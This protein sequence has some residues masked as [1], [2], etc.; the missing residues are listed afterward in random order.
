MSS[1]ED[2]PREFLSPEAF[3]NHD[4]PIAEYR[5]N[6]LIG[7]LGSI[8]TDKQIQDLLTSPFT[9]T[10]DAKQLPRHLKP[11]AAFALREFFLPDIPHMATVREIDLLIRQSYKRRNPLNRAYLAQILEDTKTL[12]HGIMLP[13]RYLFVPSLG[14]T[15]IGPPGN[16]K[17]LSCDYGLRDWAPA[18]MHSYIIK[19]ER[20]SF[21]QIPAMKINLFQDGSLKSFGL[22]IFN[23]G[24]QI[25]GIPLRRDWGVDAA[26]AGNWI[27]SLYMQFCL[28]YNVGLFVI[29]EFQ[30]I[31][32][33]HEG[34][35]RALSYFVRLMN[36]LGVAMIVVGT[37]HTAK[38]LSGDMAASRRF[39]GSIPQFAPFVAGKVWNA[40]S[41]QM[42]R[43]Q[44]VKSMDDH[45]QISAALLEASGGVRDLAV[46]LYLL[47]QM[48]LFGKAKEH[49]TPQTIA[50]TANV[51]FYTVRHRLAELKG[52]A[53]ER[54]GLSDVAK[55]VE[56]TF[57][58]QAAA[59]NERVGGAPLAQPGH[60]P[61]TSPIEISAADPQVA[62]I[63]TAAKGDSPL[64]ALTGLGLV[65]KPV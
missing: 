31:T 48:R 45:A 18:I 58:F 24:E 4:D 50:E 61:S 46:K 19:G 25:L 49:L 39:I 52:A 42:L 2:I 41:K 54:Y 14:A 32:A 23:Q 3:L 37:Q 59:E 6:P 63:K 11:H 56:K 10:E 51:L 16:G 5:G 12:E 17:T 21:W 9:Y 47:S 27:Q 57:Q 22:E 13:E 64:A 20:I 44:Y 34:H 35:R 55:Q 30:L 28:E 15:A 62:A 33:L 1:A 8:R 60:E 36:C 40:F 53:P 7:A 26:G 43:Y 65:A 38:L 29:D